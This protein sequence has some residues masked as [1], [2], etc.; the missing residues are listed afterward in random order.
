MSSCRS[1]PA[2]TI[3]GVL[4]LFWGVEEVLALLMFC[5][6]IISAMVKLFRYVVPRAPRDV[7]PITETPTEN[8]KDNPP[9]EF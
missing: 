4:A 8:N 9:E 1:I 6:G 2:A 7:E 5:P 3:V